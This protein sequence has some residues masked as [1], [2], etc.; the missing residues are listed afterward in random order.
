MMFFGLIAFVLLVTHVDAVTNACNATDRRGNKAVLTLLDVSWSV[1]RNDIFDYYLKHIFD[2][3]VGLDNEDDMT[4]LITFGKRTVVNIPF[5]SYTSTGIEN[6]FASF[7]SKKKNSETSFW[8]NKCCSP[9]TEALQMAY[10]EITRV[11]TSGELNLD[12]TDLH[13]EIFTDGRPFSNHLNPRNNQFE[14][15]SQQR[16]AISE[17]RMHLIPDLALRLKDDFNA[18]ISVHLM[19]NGEGNAIDSTENYWKG[20]GITSETS[21]IRKGGKGKRTFKR[22]KLTHV[23]RNFPIISKDVDDHIFTL[24][25]TKNKTLYNEGLHND[26]KHLCNGTIPKK[27]SACAGAKDVIFLIDSS[28]TISE[29]ENGRQRRFRD[30]VLAIPSALQGVNTEG[31]LDERTALI[32]FSKNVAVQIPLDYYSFDNFSAAVDEVRDKAEDLIDCCTPIPD[33]LGLAATMITSRT[34]YVDNPVIVM[35]ITD[36]FSAKNRGNNMP[37]EK[38][39]GNELFRQA[40]ALN[41]LPNVTTVLVSIPSKDGETQPIGLYLG[42]DTGVKSCGVNSDTDNGCKYDCIARGD[43]PCTDGSVD[44][45]WVTGA[46]DR[47]CNSGFYPAPMN[48]AIS[49][50][51]EDIDTIL[52][53]TRQLICNE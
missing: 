47:R 27:V 19:T 43:D 25:A 18:D 9:H 50:P 28:K 10:E 20:V 34:E 33:A 32:T 5:S 35:V 13:V 23:G 8:G 38:Y 17:M 41:A 45:C 36:G 31:L 44:N 46:R 16:M 26:W 3:S 49:V 2:V 51:T 29:L 52:N 30:F 39:Y 53:V 7:T 4:G 40:E 24:P 12:T 6:K 21:R 11:V 15:W 22:P 37:Y 42:D 1:K 48:R 14:A